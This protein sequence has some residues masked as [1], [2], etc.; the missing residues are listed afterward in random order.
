[1][2]RKISRRTRTCFST[3]SMEEKMSNVTDFPSRAGKPRSEYERLLAKLEDAIRG[4]DIQTVCECLIITAMSK[5]NLL[6]ESRGEPARADL[7]A[8]L[9]S[10]ARWA[11]AWG[12]QGEVVTSDGKFI[13]T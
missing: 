8:G 5:T 6:S 10:Y 9:I 3:Q 13:E 7:I 12:G 1:M 2:K 4:E 11:G